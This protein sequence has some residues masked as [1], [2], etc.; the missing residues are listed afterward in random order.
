MSDT[1]THSHAKAINPQGPTRGVSGPKTC[2]DHHPQTEPM[3]PKD[4]RCTGCYRLM[5]GIRAQQ[6]PSKCEPHVHVK[7]GETGLPGGIL[8]V[9]E[10]PGPAVK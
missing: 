7:G 4:V 9:E 3:D 5:W 10:T 1:R 6:N 8:Y 2:Y